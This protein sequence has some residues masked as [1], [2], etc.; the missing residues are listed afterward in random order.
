MSNEKYLNYYIET[1]SST[2][3]EAVLRNIS[4]QANARVT[5]EI[6]QD[7]V[8][9]IQELESLLGEMKDHDNGEIANLKKV[10]DSQQ[11]NI[12]SL[13]N[14]LNQA[15]AMRSEYESVKHQVQHIETFRNELVKTREELER[16]RNEST[17]LVEKV[18]K[19]YELKIKELNDQIEYLQLTPAKRK[20]VDEAK[21]ATVVVEV[22]KETEPVPQEVKEVT[23]AKIIKQDLPGLVVKDGGSF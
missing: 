21:A 8:K 5:D 3:S 7:Q 11:S 2:L 4:L 19:E 13:N 9:K 23:K 15:N 20:K 22:V 12:N 1:M 10:I 18:R 14:D 17:S 6:L 16:V